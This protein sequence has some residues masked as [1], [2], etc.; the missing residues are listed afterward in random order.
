MTQPIRSHCAAT[1]GPA[2]GS[3]LLAP[4]GRL[5]IVGE[6]PAKR[7]PRTESRAMGADLDSV[8]IRRARPGDAEDIAQ[9]HVD[10]WRSTYA[11][12]LPDRVLVGMSPGRH[13]VQW[14]R[15]LSHRRSSEFTVVAE[16][17]TA[18]VIG[19]GSAGP[20]RGQRRFS[21]EVF[22]LY[23]HPDFQGQGI[24]RG[25]LAALFE[26]L[27]ERGMDSAIIWVLA[28]NPS[29]FFYEAMGGELAA[30]RDE[31]LW[32]ELVPELAYGWHSLERVGRP[33]RA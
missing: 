32:G 25:L 1:G 22:T 21:G 31:R 15:L 30:Q 28:G 10:T 11:G 19:F 14:E 20:S 7:R 3:R 13:R 12:I 27:A 8:A 23:V 17:A 2:A 18:G 6:A 4:G 5:M 33:A 9:V 26:G 16:N 24:G 29:R